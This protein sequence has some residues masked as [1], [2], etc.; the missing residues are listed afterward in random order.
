MTNSESAVLTA[1]ISI[2]FQTSL[3]ISSSFLLVKSN[4]PQNFPGISML[5]N[6]FWHSSMNFYDARDVMI[7]ISDIVIIKSH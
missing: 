6:S 2:G 7:F 5:E 1:Y 4:Y 3:S